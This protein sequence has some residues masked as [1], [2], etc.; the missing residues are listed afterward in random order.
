MA[1][2]PRQRSE[3]EATGQQMPRN[4]CIS[5]RKWYKLIRHSLTGLASLFTEIGLTFTTAGDN[6]LAV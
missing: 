6:I 2:A 1:G 4:R 3:P 5:E